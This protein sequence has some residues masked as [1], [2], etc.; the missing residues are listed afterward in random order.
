MNPSPRFSS[1]T[2]FQLNAFR[3]VRLLAAAAAICTLAGT[4]RAANPAKGDIAPTVGSKLTWTGDAVGPASEGEATC[5]DGVNCDVFE[6][7]VTGE[8]GD[9]A[10]KAIQ[11]NI[12]WEVGGNDFDLV[13]RKDSVDGP[14][15]GTSGNGPPSSEEAAG[16]NPVATGTGVYIVRVIYFAFPVPADQYKG[17]AE[18]VAKQPER[19]ANY[20]KGGGITFSPNVTVKAPNTVRD[21]EPSS[22]VDFQ[23]NYYIGGIRGVPAGVD[24]W[25][26]D[27]NPSSESYDPLM[28]NPIYRGQPDSF[29]GKDKTQ[30]GADGGGD[31]DL[32]VG[33]GLPPGQEFPTVAFSSLLL[34]NISVGKSIDRG[35]TFNLNPLGNLT[36]GPPVDDREW[37]EFFGANTVFLLYRTVSPVIA[38]VHRSTDGG[39]T[40][41]PAVLVGP[42][43]Q[44]G[45]I[46]VN[47]NDG[48]V[49]CFFVDGKVAVGKPSAPGEEPTSYTFHQAATSPFGT[50]HLF[51]T[52]KVAEDGS[53]NGT[54]YVTYSNGYD[55]FLVHSTDRGE[56]WSLPVRVSDIPEGASIFPWM[57]TGKLPGSV[58][59]CWY[60]TENQKF[61]NDAA[62]WK[63]YF[64]QSF[65]ANTDNP[66]FTQVVASDH[67]IHGSNISE[68]G[69]TG[70]GNRNLIDY[71]QIV[72][73]PTG[74]AV[75][76]YTDDHNDTDGATYVTRQISGPSANGGTV[77]LPGT[78][79]APTPPTGVNE[80]PPPQPGPDGEQVTDFAQDT[81]AGAPSDIDAQNALDI[82]SIK[83]GSSEAEGK[84]LLS[85]TMKVTALTALPPNA[86]YRMTFT[87]NAPD[88][89]L[90]HT[91]D[92]TFGLSDRGD[93]FFFSVTTTAA[94]VPTYR[95][96][97][98]VRNT[99]GSITYTNVG[100]ADSGSFDSATGTITVNVDLAK[101]NTVLTD[102]GKPLI[103]RG[104]P[105]VG[106]RGTSSG[107]GISDN[108]RGGTLFVVGGGAL[109]TPTPLPTSSPAP[110][111]RLANIAGRSYVQQHDQNTSIGGFIVRGN[112][113]K[114]VLIRGIG[115]SL[116]GGGDGPLS[117][118]LSDP[119]LT[120]HGEAGVVLA[121]NDNWRNSP[122]QQQI[123]DTGIAPSDDA[124]S[125]IV[126]T[127][128]PGAYTAVLRGANQTEGVGVVEI[129]DLESGSDSELANLAF[130]AFVTT[131]DDNLIIGGL[132]LNGFTPRRVLLRGI[133]PS[134]EPFP[135][136]LANPTMQLF[137]GNGDKLA[138]NDNWRDAANAAEI[139][140][141]GIA[142]K[143]DAESAILMPLSAGGYTAIVNGAPSAGG[144]GHG[145]GN[146]V[147]EIYRLD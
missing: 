13:I 88:S 85:A 9:Y 70:A 28:R 48:T 147:V 6:I 103:Q 65:N 34:A 19:S 40:Y 86:T 57:E 96:G 75:I 60:G 53:P 18:T 8:P 51:V 89:V 83:Y 59:L 122:E 146:G 116:K 84:T 62:N 58:V 81:R 87:A 130:R 136:T 132:I 138:E 31:I 135:N 129:Y 139:S 141:T 39:F 102:A 73:D 17:V 42:S 93:Q 106:L 124:E 20:L 114:R 55:V 63:V 115:P 121:E 111:V 44:V 24:L 16:I 66:T 80:A 46:D 32:A 26:F 127:L 123:Q 108:T 56:T 105:L 11:V 112:T 91:G 117:G 36:G 119:T 145:T 133:G 125:A 29:T 41:G 43:S 142:P 107:G 35:A 120:L 67:F 47:Q 37:Q 110:P 118:R 52:G 25:N 74:A 140:D 92:Y 131:G 95:Y 23:G 14:V 5:V 82:V 21:G 78:I 30:V 45:G 72:V 143:N 100:T 99:D 71:F 77:S 61:N 12:D 2:R 64:A 49:Y 15:V 137:N 90:S 33:F 104:S 128:P 144:G 22:R 79:P 101:F 38:L 1:V 134:L 10:G 76:G 3:T 68:G 113:P 98:A 97:T 4:A 50:R 109:P 27:L 69:L 94:N 7:N 54:V 126:R